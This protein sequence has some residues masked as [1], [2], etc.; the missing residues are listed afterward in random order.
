MSLLDSSF[1][2]L[3]SSSSSGLWR[4]SGFIQL[5]FCASCACY[6]KFEEFCPCFGNESLASA[7]IT[8]GGLT[9]GFTGCAPANFFFGF[10]IRW[11]LL[12]L[13]ILWLAFRNWGILC[14]MS[15]LP[16]R[17][18]GHLFSSSSGFWVRWFH[19]AL[20]FASCDWD[21]KFELLNPR[22]APK[23]Q[24]YCIVRFGGKLI[25]GLIMWHVRS[26]FRALG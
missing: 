25:P 22:R 3:L 6:S 9:P 19:F 17:S 1:G 13:C 12:F 23:K 15:E 8:G 24:E 2:H 5:C 20:F 16:D 14:K 4:L 18:F 7:E 10:W 11:V 26:F 21:S